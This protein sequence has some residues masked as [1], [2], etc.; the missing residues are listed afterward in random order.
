MRSLSELTGA[1]A[2][3]AP[4]RGAMR[5]RP[6]ATADRWAASITAPDREAA[7]GRVAATRGGGSTCSA[8]A[9]VAS[10]KDARHRPSIFSNDEVSLKLG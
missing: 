7:T 1:V 6:A 5:D 8:A 9:P 10:K 3:T 4:D 2:T